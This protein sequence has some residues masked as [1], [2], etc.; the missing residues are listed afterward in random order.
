[1]GAASTV[2]VTICP[3]SSSIIASDSNTLVQVS[4]C[5]PREL[6]AVGRIRN[7][8]IYIGKRASKNTFKF[9]KCPPLGR[10][11]ICFCSLY[12]PLHPEVSKWLGLL[13]FWDIGRQ[14][15]LHSPHLQSPEFFLYKT[16]NSNKIN[17]L[18]TLSS[19]GLHAS[20]RMQKKELI[21]T[22]HVQSTYKG[23]HTHTCTHACMHARTHTH[24][25]MCMFMHQGF[26]CQI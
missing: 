6:L 22:T 10:N 21:H 7:S 5:P 20:V 26:S 13:P 11:F 16:L 2:L 25:H 23:T 8:K 4:T 15:S 1:M 17:T 14:A 3:E 9:T 12:P 18:S 19:S 24:T